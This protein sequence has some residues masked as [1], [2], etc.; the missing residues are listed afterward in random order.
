[1]PI[2][3]SAK[4]ALRVQEKKTEVNRRRKAVL[5]VALKSASAETLARTFS[6]IDKSAKWGII[7]AN[8]AS[9]LKSRL[10]KEIGT[11]GKAKPSSEKAP[12][13]KKPV[14]KKAVAKSKTSKAKQ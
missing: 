12:A 13:T 4:K 10:S 14:A 3:K 9:R 6:L 8:K 1:M 11:S 5:K 7:A 2:S